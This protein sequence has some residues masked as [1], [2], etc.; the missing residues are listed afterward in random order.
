MVGIADNQLDV[1]FQDGM[2]RLPVDAG[3]LHAD[4]R[5]AHLREP[6]PQSLQIPGHG[7]KRSDFLARFAAGFPDQHT[8]NHRRLMDIETG[9][10]FDDSFHNHLPE[11][12][13]T[14]TPQVEDRNC[15]TC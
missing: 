7:R 2:D 12:V 10:P 1:A 5:D 8:G 11:P 9:A 6:V 13:T 3:A 15:P 4:M 14:A